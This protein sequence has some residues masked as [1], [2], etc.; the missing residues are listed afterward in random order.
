[1][2][3]P[4]YTLAKIARILKRNPATVRSW[5]SLAKRAA[6]LEGEPPNSLS[7]TDVATPEF[8]IV[9]ATPDAQAHTEEV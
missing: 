4:V 6:A 7:T 1:M 9:G 2:G 5:V 3:Q 8:S